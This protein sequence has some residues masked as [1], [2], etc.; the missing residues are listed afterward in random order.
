MHVARRTFVVIRL[1][2]IN[3]SNQGMVWEVTEQAS[4][5]RAELFVQS[6]W[7]QKSLLYQH[8]P[9]GHMVIHNAIRNAKCLHFE[10]EF[11]YTHNL[12]YHQKITKEL[13]WGQKSTTGSIEK[14]LFCTS[15]ACDGMYNDG[16][17]LHRHQESKHSVMK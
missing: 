2:A 14:N 10:K 8:L 9:G 7:L 3:C 5:R 15:A 1:V 16:R 4:I 13:H 12:I 17:S 6:S 11:A